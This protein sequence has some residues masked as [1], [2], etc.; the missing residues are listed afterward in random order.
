VEWESKTDICKAQDLRK[1]LLSVV[2]GV[3]SDDVCKLLSAVDQAEHRS[4]IPPLD[5]GQPRFYWIFKN[6]D[7]AQWDSGNSP[8]LWLSGPT[9][10][11]IDQVS[12]NIVNHEMEAASRSQHLV[13]YFFC[14]T[15]PR[16]KS[17]I[18]V[19][20]HTILRQLISRLPEQEKAIVTAFLQTL[21]DG[22]FGRDPSRFTAGDRS[23]TT[24]KKILDAST[25]E[26]WDALMAALD[27]ERERK[28]TIIIDR[29]EQQAI[30]FTDGLDKLVEY[31]LGRPLK[32]KALLTSRLV[33]NIKEKLLNGLLHIEYDKERKGLPRSVPPHIRGSQS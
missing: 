1:I 33:T 12:S 21:L 28:L 6:C 22:V 24:I 10:C 17:I 13:L 3:N 19:F 16:A 7:F 32:V 9:E 5:R 26:L 11:S 23:D 14:S 29:V 20:V 27:V 15:V 18:I 8:V 4:T 30:D 2:N 31:L 25:S